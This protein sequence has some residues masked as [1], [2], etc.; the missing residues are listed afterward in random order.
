MPVG[1]ISSVPQVIVVN[2]QRVAART[3]PELLDYLRKS[4]DQPPPVSP[5]V[6]LLLGRPARGF[7][8]WAVDHRA[9]FIG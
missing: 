5:E 7:A 3:L 8:Q 4:V 1:L 9:A 2:P 6:P